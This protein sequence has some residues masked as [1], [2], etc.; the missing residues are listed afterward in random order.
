MNPPNSELSRFGRFIL[1]GITNTLVDFGLLNL[2]VGI[3][4]W[5]LLISQGLSF[6]IA[7]V[8]SYVLSRKFVYPE[9]HSGSI[10]HQFPKFLTINLVGL[11]IRSLI[12]PPLNHIFLNVFVQFSVF[13]FTPEFL[14]RNAALVVTTSLILLL[15]F[16][17]NRYWTF[18]AAEEPQ[19]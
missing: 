19:A 7:V 13:S 9:A 15:N 3:F 11:G 10:A 14:A 5:P 2:F 1:V 16:L 18:Q 17:A 4:K 8:N 12:I 6:T